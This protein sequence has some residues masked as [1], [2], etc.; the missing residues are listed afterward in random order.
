MVKAPL[1]QK[2]SRDYLVRCKQEPQLKVKPKI[3][4][5]KAKIFSTLILIGLLLGCSVIRPQ[6][7]PVATKTENKKDTANL[8]EFCEYLAKAGLVKSWKEFTEVPFVFEITDEQDTPASYSWLVIKLDGNSF[9]VQTDSLGMASLRFDEKMLRQNPNVMT[10]DPS[11][12]LKFN[13][14]I[15]F[16]LGG[17]TELNVVE[18]HELT[19]VWAGNDLLYYPQENDILVSELQNNLPLMRNA[20]ESVLGISAIPYGIVLC[21]THKPIILSRNQANINGQRY[22]LWPIS[23][24]DDG[25]EDYYLAVIHEWT[26]STLNKAI[27]FSEYRMRW[28]TDGISEYISLEFARS[29]SQAKR[30][31]INLTSVLSKR[32]SS[33]NGFVNQLLKEGET[34]LEFDLVGWTSVSAEHPIAEPDVVGYGLGLYFWTSLAEELGVEIIHNFLEGAK[35][36]ENPTGDD[37]VGLLASLTGKD[38]RKMLTNFDLLDIKRKIELISDELKLELE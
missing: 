2:T 12:L 1:T 34:E 16:P 3:V 15:L 8:R 14:A 24:L 30:D 23:L 28:V 38:I 27:S 4:H 7:K 35:N 29:L 22:S 19:R 31:S 5:R 13:F 33:Y 10:L 11:K 17:A 26:E 20:I 25:P 18:L 32:F 6:S 36:L 9:M 37:L 21:N